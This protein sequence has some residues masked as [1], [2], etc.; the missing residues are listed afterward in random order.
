MGRKI[1]CY[2]SDG[3]DYAR[4][5]MSAWSV[6]KHFGDD[7]EIFLLTDHYWPPAVHGIK[8]V[9]PASAIRDV[10]MFPYAWNRYL[11][12]SALFRLAIPLL[13]EFKDA[14]RVLY[15]D[16]DTLVMSP[17]AKDMVFEA[18]LGEYEVKMAYDVEDGRG[19]IP[20]LL[21][22]D[23][24]EYARGVMAPYFEKWGTYSR[25]YCNSGVALFNLRQLRA[26][27]L[28][29]Y[30]RRLRMFW[31]I[32]LHGKF[33][34]IDQDFMNV[35]MHVDTFL[36]VRLNAIEGSKFTEPVFIR[37][38]ASPPNQ[39]SEQAETAERLGYH[40]CAAACRDMVR[41]E[42]DLSG[43]KQLVVFMSH[44][45]SEE[46][47]WRYRKLRDDVVHLN[48]DVVWWYNFQPGRK[49]D[50]PDDIWHEDADSVLDIYEYVAP[51][52]TAY[53]SAGAYGSMTM[54]EKYREYDYMWIVEYD[55]CYS[56]NWADFF[57]RMNRQPHDLICER[58]TSR[59][60]DSGWMWWPISNLTER[61]WHW[62]DQFKS[63]VS[64]ARL[65]RRMMDRL[66]D[67]YKSIR[68]K[69]HAYY[70]CL[71]PTIA[72]NEMS[73]L[74]IY[75]AECDPAYNFTVY[76]MKGGIKTDKLYHAVKDNV[77]W[78]DYL[79]GAAS[80]VPAC[81][82]SNVI[83]MRPENWHGALRNL[84]GFTGMED[85]CM[86]EVGSYAGESTE[87]FASS[88]RTGT[89]WCIDPWKPGYDANDA[90][91]GSDFAA[92]EACFDAVAGKYP[93]K[94]RKFKGTLHE[95]ID[96]HPEVKPDLVYIDACHNYESAKHDILAAM[97]LAPGFIAGHDYDNYFSGVVKA[98]DEVLGGPTA[99]LKD[100]SWLKVMR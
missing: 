55:V 33:R 40:C 85:I 31:D 91:S 15:L 78:R 86:L 41:S 7:V 95:F 13:D 92:V 49:A 20:T 37:H 69:P 48:M 36:D 17:Q 22:E 74:D 11:P 84:L 83:S 75:P 97:S 81:G 58:L 34:C 65:S 16:T 61:Y 87:E 99:V 73:C 60:K 2:A 79:V 47:I 94:I 72:V 63:L 52:S 19:R 77:A 27:G 18:N 68:G 50:F 25:V 28:D 56:G 35:F 70:E 9:N 93:G 88:P 66:L 26:N 89:I 24:D 32:Q 59:Y 80:G 53:H 43:K 39:K 10:G 64:I 5:E 62:K 29:W 90:A 96:A 82:G 44:V 21:D 6:R 4:L 98:V 38:Y 46:T 1:V 76:D 42:C 30:T 23:V 71:W 100:T 12:F 67:V 8:V 45:V 14:D 51:V 54:A 57:A 3:N